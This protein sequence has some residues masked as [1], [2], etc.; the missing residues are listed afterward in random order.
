[1]MLVEQLPV[2]LLGLFVLSLADCGTGSENVD[3]IISTLKDISEIL[4]NNGYNSWGNTI[5]KAIVLMKEQKPVE[6]VLDQDSMVCGV[7]GHEVIWQK[8]LGSDVLLDEQLDYCPH[9][10]R[11]VKWE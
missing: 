1:M 10:G 11:Q 2:L 4:F 3:E 5:R 7:C 8:L 6:P 9:C